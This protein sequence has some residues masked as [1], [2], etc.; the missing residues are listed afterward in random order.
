MYQPGMALRV[1]DIVVRKIYI[2]CLYG[3]YSVMT[4]T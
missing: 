1:K 3:S 2:S 4:K